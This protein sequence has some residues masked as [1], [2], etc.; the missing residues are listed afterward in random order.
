MTPP[1]PLPRPLSAAPRP[2]LALSSSSPIASTP[3]VPLTAYPSTP[4]RPHFLLPLH[5]SSN[6]TPVFVSKF[7]ISRARTTFAL[8]SNSRSLARVFSHF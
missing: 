2:F 1:L 8:L 5:A 7:Q 4:S 6:I 3:T